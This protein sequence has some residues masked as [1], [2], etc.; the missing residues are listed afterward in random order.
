MLR[1]AT[2]SAAM[3]SVPCA[4]SDSASRRL[5]A[6]SAASDGSCSKDTSSCSRLAERG[7]S[8]RGG[9]A[10]LT[11][12]RAESSAKLVRTITTRTN[13]RLLSGYIFF[14]RCLS[15][16]R[17]RAPLATERSQSVPRQNR[18]AL[19]PHAT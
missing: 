6:C 3:V 16:L 5:P 14:A 10:A 2:P 17:V 4:N 15:P 19:H 13:E 9:S 1:R 18:I 8:E 7:S 11:A 12:R